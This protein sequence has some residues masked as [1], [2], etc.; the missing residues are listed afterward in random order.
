[1]LDENKYFDAEKMIDEAVKL[2]P[3]FSLPANFADAI[4]KR[5]GQK[6]AWEQYIKEFMIYLGVIVGIAAVWFGVSVI[7]F[8]SDWKSW[9]DLVIANAGIVIGLNIIVLFILFAD[10]VLLRYLFFK[11]SAENQ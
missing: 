2:E 6:F 8:G 9:L 3:R 1:M 4:A 11:S 5:V 7:W 10:K